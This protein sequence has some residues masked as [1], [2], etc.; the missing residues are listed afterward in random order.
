MQIHD[1]LA[2]QGPCFFGCFHTD[3]EIAVLFGDHAVFDKL[4][5]FNNTVPLLAVE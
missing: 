4:I 3:H 2:N 1:V 5:E